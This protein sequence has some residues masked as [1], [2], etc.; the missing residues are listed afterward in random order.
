M[1]SQDLNSQGMVSSHTIKPKIKPV[2]DYILGPYSDMYAPVEEFLG[3]R[4]HFFQNVVK[5]SIDPNPASAS[6]PLASKK[7]E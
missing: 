1:L 5:T 6:C 4:A 3:E 2:L 7:C